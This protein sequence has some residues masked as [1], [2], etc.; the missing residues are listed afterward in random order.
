[1][2]GG[3]HV[4]V[5]VTHIHQDGPNTTRGREQRWIYRGRKKKHVNWIIL[6]IFVLIHLLTISERPCPAVA[7]QLAEWPLPGRHLFSRQIKS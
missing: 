3:H 4:C 7:R 1:M 5:C 2:G 6:E